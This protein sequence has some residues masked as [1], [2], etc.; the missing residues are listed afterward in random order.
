M[1]SLVIGLGLRM[2]VHGAPTLAEANLPLVSGNKTIAMESFAPA[3]AGRFPAVVLLHGSEGLVV[4]GVR[5]RGL[6]RQ[7]ADQGFIVFIPHYFERT[8]TQTAGPEDYRKGFGLWQETIRDAITYAARQPQV[9]EG[10]VGLVGFSLGSYL[11]LGVAAQSPQIRAV[12]EFFGG[13]PDQGTQPFKG[14][15]PTLILHGEKDTVVPVQEAY[16]LADLLK[17][18]KSPFEIKVYPDQ[19]HGFE[20]TALIDSLARTLVFLKQYL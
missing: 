14:L 3:S 18:R 17:A 10:R 12:V 20:G 6:A 15:P 13:L 9:A 19:G 11:S 1:V 8:G 16:R 5:Y 2:P 4:N 7:L